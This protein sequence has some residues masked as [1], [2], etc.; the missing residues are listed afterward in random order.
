[1]LI[2]SV[3]EKKL[4]TSA[5][6]LVLQIHVIRLSCLWRLKGVAITEN[7]SGIGMFAG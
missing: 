4:I 1:M 5:V 6:T 2:L 7:S 3:W